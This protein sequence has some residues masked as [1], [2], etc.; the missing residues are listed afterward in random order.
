MR[1]EW[2][3]KSSKRILGFSFGG[4]VPAD[5]VQRKHR[6]REMRWDKVG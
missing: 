1:G 6:V 3:G 4:V 2:V 5:R